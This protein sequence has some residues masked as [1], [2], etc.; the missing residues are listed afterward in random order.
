VTVRQ[1]IV[2]KIC[3]R[4]IQPWARNGVMR[5]RQLSIWSKPHRPDLAPRPR[6]PQ[7]IG[8]LSRRGTFRRRSPRQ[9][10]IV[11]M[12]SNDGLRNAARRHLDTGLGRAVCRRM[13]CEPK[14]SY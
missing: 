4:D 7:S 6:W 13:C 3:H 12:R 5:R 14:L 2:G 9:A 8:Q 11:S 10:P 1:N